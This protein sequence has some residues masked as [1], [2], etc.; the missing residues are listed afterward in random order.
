ML[1]LCLAEKGT[2]QTPG[3]VSVSLTSWFKANAGAGN[4]L[5][6]TNNLTQINEWKSELGNMSVTQATAT[7][8]PLYLA[9]YTTT[10]NFNFNP[11]LQFAAS[12]KMGLLNT[13]ATAPDILGNNGTYFLVLNTNRETGFTSSTCFSY[14]SG[15]TGARYQAKAD[16]RIQTGIS[17][18]GYIAD[19]DPAATG[20][21][22]AGIPAIT[23]ARASAVVLASRSAGPTFRARR[24]ADTT[25]LGSGS[26]YNP[27]IGAGLGIGFN[28]PGGSEASSSAIAEVIT[29]NTYL[30]DADVNKV[31]S[32]LAVKY[33]ITLSQSNTFTVPAG[34]TSYTAGNGTVIW[35][36]AANTGYGK[37]ITGIG[38][39]DA[40]AL[41]QKQSRSVHDSSLVY[42]YNDN[43]GGVF[44]AMNV[45][46]PTVFAAG[47]SFLLFGDN[48]L[49]RDLT[50]CIYNGKITRMQRTWKVQKTG[51]VGAV[52]LAVDATAV[53]VAVKNLLVSTD[54]LFP[55]SSTT[56]YPLS[57]ANGKLYAPVNLNSNEY[58]T[59]ASDSLKVVMTV[60]QPSCAAINGGAVTATVTGG[61]APNTYNWNTTP[62]QTTANATGLTGGNYQLTVK[63]ASG[64][65]AV[66]PVTLVTPAFQ[67][68]ASFTVSDS[69]VCAGTVITATFTGTAPN[70]ATANWSWGGG[71]VQSGS[72]FGPYTIKYD[73]SGILGLT[74]KDGSCAL[75]ARS[76]LI[77]VIPAPEAAFT[78]DDSTGCFPFTVT[79]NNQ[80]Q[81]TDAWK[82]S[83]GDGGTATG[84]SPSYTY[85]K[86]GVYSVTLIASSQGK[87]FDTLEQKNVIQVSA[88]PEASFT[89]TPGENIP[90]ELHLASFTFANAS[91]NATGYLWDFG[92]GSTA[93]AVNPTHQYQAPGNYTVTLQI[94]N[95]AGCADTAIRQFLLVIPDKVLI[96]PNAFSP[97]G[98]GINDKW[99]IAG[100]RTAKDCQVEIFNRWGQLIYSSTGYGVPWDGT[101]N[102][103]ALPVATYYYIIKTATGDYHGWVALVR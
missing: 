93:S 36:G 56:I 35:N 37:C 102:G 14:N 73:K 94:V 4:V 61:V 68:T 46:N 71:T 11:A 74:V 48:G 5:P 63:A 89:V 32:Y 18:F 58:F 34:P 17:G 6:N 33:G 7:N 49:S 85:N 16:F 87:C 70:T 97:N 13:S 90:V 25:V 79:F 65:S 81:N 47:N 9:N 91:Q 27:A 12:Q 23:Y 22:A 45:N 92:D 64:C 83:F 24:N 69:L 95:G 88:Y 2:A 30:S 10:A 40:S 86:P 99:E 42:L 66:Y 98:D 57:T 28:S 29:Y 77:N 15:G 55:E 20:L 76:K 75:A 38:R 52:T 21:N 84:V 3:G 62:V 53:H 54:P 41:I 39:D 67:G 100:L 96:I 78:P 72:G 59:F 101:L 103:N 43:T 26:I 44:P 80:S 51:T 50:T 82:W 31:E 1:V 60:T 8:M 19:L